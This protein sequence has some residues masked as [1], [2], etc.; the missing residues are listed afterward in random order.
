MTTS[1]VTPKNLQHIR[2]Y[3][4]KLLLKTR[5]YAT[6][7]ALKVAILN[8]IEYDN[9]EYSNYVTGLSSAEIENFFNRFKIV[10]SLKIV[11]DNFKD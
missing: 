9:V 3:H 1:T 11:D 7:R 8:S 5:R 4:L 2:H 10:K 6:V